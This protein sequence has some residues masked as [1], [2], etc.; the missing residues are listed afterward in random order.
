MPAHHRSLRSVDPAA[1][2][3]PRQRTPR[4]GRRTT[5]R[6]LALVAAL[7]CVVAAAACG[8][9]APPSALRP[10][11]PQAATPQAS[12]SL[13][14]SE[15]PATAAATT[16]LLSSRQLSETR[17]I[18]VYT[19][20]G[21]AATAVRVPVLY[22]PDGGTEEDFPHLT[23]TV[24]RLI[25]SRAIPPILVVGIENT[26]RRRDLTGPTAVAKDRE[27]APRVGG[28]SAF[29]TFLREEL[30]PDIR[31][32]Y[33]TT[34][35]T[36]IVG[37]SLAG[38]FVVE[39]LLLEP[40]LF[41]RYIALSPSL[42]W[43]AERLATDAAAHLSQLPAEPRALF[44]ASAGDDLLPGIE[45]FAAALRSSAPATLTWTYQ[46]HPQLHHSTIYRSLSAPALTAIYA[47]PTV[48]GGNASAG[49][50]RGVL[51]R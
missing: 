22:M 10:A 18:N 25:R 34:D 47:R 1:A 43:N 4:R 6:R 30:M 50:A 42:W 14:P 16:F 21:Y 13:S 35:D 48:D 7:A 5:R 24:D 51:C 46:P 44:L 39:T 15:M 32:R 19:P 45:R 2:L 29:R 17:R 40:S 27:I 3:A 28:S 31:R 41:R 12:A 49:S 36:A 23:A 26:E 11:A 9:Q 20:P 33:C 8:S 38:L 37:E